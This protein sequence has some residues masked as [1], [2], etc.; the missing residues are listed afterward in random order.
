VIRSR[1]LSAAALLAGAL[2]L[3]SCTKPADTPAPAPLDKAK[4]SGVTVDVGQL[5]HGR[6]PKLAWFNGSTLHQGSR[7]TK[8][9]GEPPTEVA[10]TP[11]RIVTWGPSD[12]GEPAVHVGTL[13]A[14]VT[15]DFP[16]PT[17]G[18]VTNAQRN[19]VAWVTDDGT[20]Q[21]LQDGRP[22][23]ITLPKAT[24][25][26]AP[27][28]VAILGHDC[29]NGPE[30]VAGAGCSVFFTISHDRMTESMVSSTH[31]FVEK[32]S[33]KIAELQDVSPRQAKI[34]LTVTG[35]NRLCSRY[36]SEPKNYKTC[37]Y[38]PRT[39]SSNGKRFIAFSSEVGEGPATN[40]ISVRDA[41]SGK[42]LLTARSP[43]GEATIWDARWEDGSHLLAVVNQDEKFSIV[44][45]G[46]DGKVERA[47]GPVESPSAN[48]SLTVQP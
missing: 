22:E 39:F 44:R 9:P 35:G 23:P 29:F 2:L 40:E 4:A 7:T 43:K 28:A 26:D 46:L 32:A 3:A 36:E 47:V 34:G 13:D 25:G 48:F 21:V 10:I 6:S 42:A 37:A 12:S 41:E 17:S 16:S 18:L 33:D 1:W 5:R 15:E 14:D 8:L 24:V 19:L 38:F 31:G 11:D 45:I 30:T 27:D 20:P